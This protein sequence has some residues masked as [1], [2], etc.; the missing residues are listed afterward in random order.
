[1]DWKE[2]ASKGCRSIRRYFPKSNGNASRLY[3]HGDNFNAGSCP[4][5]RYDENCGEL[6]G[7]QV[8]TAEEELNLPRK[9]LGS[10]GPRD[11]VPMNIRDRLCQKRKAFNAQASTMSADQ[12]VLAGVGERIK[13]RVRLRHGSP[14]GTA[15][16]Q[17]AV[18]QNVTNMDRDTTPIT[19]EEQGVLLFI[20]WFWYE[21]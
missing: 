20:I 5:G 13:Q 4:S 10:N 7:S 14:S 17:S 3:Q 11:D 12:G 18:L 9:R 8:V 15:L 19:P 21:K 6:A 2:K 16:A 1:M